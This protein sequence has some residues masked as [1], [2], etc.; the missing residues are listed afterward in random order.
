MTGHWCF[1]Q[2]LGT[3]YK[4]END[5]HDTHRFNRNPLH[6]LHTLSS[7]HLYGSPM[8]GPKMPHGE[9]VERDPIHA[10]GKNG[11][12]DSVLIINTL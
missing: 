11:N 3:N 1:T 9:E 12:H 7:K 4:H 8:Y 6:D 5:L 2:H 10:N